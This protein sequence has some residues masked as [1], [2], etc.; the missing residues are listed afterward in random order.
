[1]ISI[2]LKRILEAGDD[3]CE[4]R[5]SSTC[6]IL[7]LRDIAHAGPFLINSNVPGID[8]IYSFSA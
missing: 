7:V 6:H 5:W 1:V 4:L 3:A 8:R 2:N